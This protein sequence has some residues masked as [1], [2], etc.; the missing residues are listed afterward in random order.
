MRRVCY[1]PRRSIRFDAYGSAFEPS[2]SP[3]ESNSQIRKRR[4]AV[5]QSIGE[6]ADFDVGK[7]LME[8]QWRD[9]TWAEYSRF[10][11]ENLL[12]LDEGALLKKQGYSIHDLCTLPTALVPFGGLD[13]I[14]LRA[15]ETIIIA[16]VSRPISLR[17]LI[18]IRDVASR[19]TAT[20]FQFA[21]A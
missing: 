7:P 2:E 1:C 17:L 11:L 19:C 10:P 14:G 8:H 16:P 3:S 9:S 21:T 20:I 15:G 18:A 4:P 12:P 5:G 6:Q 13:E